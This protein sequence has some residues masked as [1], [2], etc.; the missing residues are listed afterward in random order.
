MKV[1]NNIIG[2]KIKVAR[3]NSASPVSD[4]EARNIDLE[5]GIQIDG[6]FLKLE[7]PEFLVR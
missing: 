2:F 5:K 3:E 1:L 7:K 6:E 4:R